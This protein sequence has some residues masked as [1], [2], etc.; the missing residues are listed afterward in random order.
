MRLLAALLL[1]TLVPTQ[2]L[3]AAE[4]IDGIA[5]QVGSEIVLVSEVLQAAAPAEARIREEGGGEKDVAVLHLEILE[6][7]IE[8]ALIRQMVKRAELDASDAEVDQAV[9]D[10]AHENQL[11]LEELR[12][13]VDAQGMPFETYREKIR[14]EIEHQKVMSG[15]VASKVRLGDK[16]VREIF[17]R[18]FSNQP[19]GGEEFYL[20]QILVTF[21]ED[22]KSGRTTACMRVGAARARIASGETF[23]DVASQLSEV[24]PEVGG[25]IGWLHENEVAG[26]MLRAVADLEPGDVSQVVEAP[27]GCNLIEVVE[28]RPYQQITWEQAREPLHAQLFEQ[29]MAE[30]YRKFVDKMRDQ[31]YIERKGMFAE[32]A[33]ELRLDTDDD[34]F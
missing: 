12:A 21:P 28:R 25:T 34:T 30:E 16:E 22:E 20:R 24:N 19:S 8:R 33:A 2:P 17:D 5:A 4:V 10:I 31:T 11:T 6:R 1:A 23:R 7:M 13:T 9:A 32:N 26:W 27:F 18:E 3:R 14:G 15:M 29:R